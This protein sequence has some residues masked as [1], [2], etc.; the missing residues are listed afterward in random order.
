MR[1]VQAAICVVL[2]VPTTLQPVMAFAE[3]VPNGLQSEVTQALK[4]K[5]GAP[6]TAQISFDQYYRTVNG[7]IVCGEVAAHGTPQPFYFIK[8]DTTGALTGAV[9]HTEAERDM[10]SM[11]CKG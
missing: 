3:S 4:N 1:P 6:S 8:V 10:A 7:A 2:C 9:V 5:L 11:V